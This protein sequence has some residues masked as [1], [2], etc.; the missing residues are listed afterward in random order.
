MPS[1]IGLR[2]QTAEA[3]ADRRDLGAGTCI[4]RDAEG[5]LTLPAALLAGLGLAPGDEITLTR[6]GQRLVLTSD[7]LRRVYIE[8]TSH[9]NLSYASC[10]RHA[11]TEPMGHMPMERY[12]RLLAGLPQRAEAVT[13]AF[14][15]FGEP[16]AHPQFLDMVRLARAQ[17]LRVALTTNGTLLEPAI[18]RSL[19]E[20]GVA[21]VAV[22]VD[23]PDQASYASIRET[24]LAP[25]LAHITGLQEAR[26]RARS[27]MRLGLAFVAMRRNIE[28]LPELLRLAAELQMDFVSISNLIPH[29]PEMAA[30]ALWGKAA[31]AANFPDE[32][33]GPQI[34]LGRM[35]MDELTASALNP[36][37]RRGPVLPPPGLGGAEPTNYCRFVHEGTLAVAWDGRV[38]PCLS[39][40]HSHPEYIYGHWKQVWAYKVGNVDDQALSEVW[41]QAAFR[42][43]R[44]RVRAFDFP[45]CFVC[46]GCPSTASNEED[47]YG[48]PFPVCSECLW[49]QGIVLCP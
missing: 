6:E 24:A 26:R 49:A 9:C 48:D 47:C 1:T 16:L 14:G 22:S 32:S 43:F 35:D 34:R 19:V 15:G 11:W 3:S 29:T 10:I 17:E 27:R 12:R 21:Q 30:E 8:L 18:A 41:Q 23:G 31:W 45:G 39:L 4:S 42:D 13:L 38:A 28:A 25:V 40:L 5:N 20:L 2:E 37:W 36:L 7:T 46:G 33:W 44:R